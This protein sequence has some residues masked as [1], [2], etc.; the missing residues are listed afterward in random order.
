MAQSRF[1]EGRLTTGYIAEEF[2]EGFTGVALDEAALRRLAA[3]GLLL[4]L[5]ARHARL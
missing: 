3:L 5:R 1:R 4:G 2:P